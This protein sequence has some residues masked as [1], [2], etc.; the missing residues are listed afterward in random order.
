MSYKISVWIALFLVSFNGG[1]V[2]L[3]VSGT[4]DYL[5]VQPD[6]GNTD[7]IDRAKQSVEEV[8][9]GGGGGDT[10]FGL[11]NTIA[12]PIE[13][14]FDTIMPGAKML[15]NVGVPDYLVNFTF[16]TLA[17]IPGIDFILFMRRG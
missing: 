4:Y 8:N 9:T 1:H 15:K 10:L 2:M 13:T 5:G 6:L 11:Y 14:I 16:G 7:Q 3:D 12:G 17:L